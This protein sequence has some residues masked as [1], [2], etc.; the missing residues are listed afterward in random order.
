MSRPSDAVTPAQPVA[1]PGKFRSAAVLTFDLDAEA[2]VLSMDPA[3]AG[4]MSVM[5]HQ[6]YGPLVGVPRLL[7]IL[8]ARSVRATFFV[9]GYTA[10]RYP[11]VVHA[12]ADAG[13]EIA[14]H[15]YRHESMLGRSAE[16]EAAI[17]D[18]GLAAFDRIGLARPAGYRAPLWELNYHTPGLLA[19]RGFRY[20]S[21]L[22]DADVPYPL[23]PGLVEVPVHWG[24]DDWEQYAYLPGITGS[25]VIESPGKVREMWTDEF[26]AMHEEGGCF[27]LTCHPFLSGR[28]SRAR[29]LAGLIDTMTATE[30]VWLTTM[31]EIADHVAGLRLAPRR[32]E[33][34]EP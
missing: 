13:H 6:A 14:H 1:W 8:A 2:A 25:G 5:S 16:E 28:P 15:G 26:T 20:D 17:I 12:I 30:G 11:S 19:E 7:R 31:A 18:R 23:T 22:M 9:P 4:R 32:I 27:V 29:A 33:V 10:E 24:L 34:P 3:S 21:S